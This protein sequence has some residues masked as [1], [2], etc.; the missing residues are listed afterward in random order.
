MYD[1]EWKTGVIVEFSDVCYSKRKNRFV[2]NQFLSNQMQT[3]G[4][5]LPCLLKIE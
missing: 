5:L 4:T 3:N 1:L 2:K